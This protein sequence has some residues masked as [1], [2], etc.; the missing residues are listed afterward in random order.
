MTT[1]QNNNPL[2]G[3][4]PDADEYINPADGR[5]SIARDFMAESVIAGEVS[6]LYARASLASAEGRNDE[7]DELMQEAHKRVAAL[8]LAMG[9]WGP[10]PV[11]RRA[12]L[13]P[14]DAAKVA[15]AKQ[16]D[17]EVEK[18][19]LRDKKQRDAT[20]AKERGHAKAKR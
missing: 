13:S 17:A 7:R 6:S 12:E 19:A 20:E 16:R 15:D 3:L 10:A 5:S 9:E 4:N 8:A 1:K 11:A 14:V 2:A 18:Q